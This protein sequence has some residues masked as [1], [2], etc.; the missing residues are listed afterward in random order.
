M[1]NDNSVNGFIIKVGTVLGVAFSATILIA[2]WRGFYHA[3][4]DDTSWLNCV[5]F[6]AVVMMTGRQYRENVEKETFRYA[7]AYIYLTKLN[8]ISALILSVFGFFYY[9]NISPED[10]SE[11]LRQI[12]T[13]SCQIEYFTA[14]Q[15]ES[16]TKSITVGQMA[17]VMFVYQFIGMSLVGLLLAN[18]IKSKKLPVT[19]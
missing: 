15:I 1:T 16:F 10:F 12:E 3:P 9:N 5:I 13:A 7:R 6:M 17:F 8:L 4:L 18:I 14:E 2:H 11:I 19:E